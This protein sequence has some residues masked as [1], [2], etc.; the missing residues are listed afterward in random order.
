MVVGTVTLGSIVILLFTLLPPKTMIWLILAVDVT[1]LSTTPLTVTTID[2]AARGRGLA[3]L[4]NLDLVGDV[5]VSVWQ[6]G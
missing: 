4:R 5:D 2:D 3:Y 1:A 6:R